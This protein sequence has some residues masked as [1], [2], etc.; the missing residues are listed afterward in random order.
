[1]VRTNIDIDDD[2]MREAMRASGER[3]KRAVVERALRLLVQT[4]GQTRIRR[5]RGKVTWRG[6]LNESR[7]ARGAT[8]D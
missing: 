1:V 5:L 6:D 8:S 3:T 4:R 7:R 2:L